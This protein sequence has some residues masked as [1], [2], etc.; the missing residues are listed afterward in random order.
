M[1]E[2]PDKFDGTEF[3]KEVY[4]RENNYEPSIERCG[5]CSDLHSPESLEYCEQCKKRICKCC[6]IEIEG[7]YFCGDSETGESACFD[8]YEDCRI[9]ELC[10]QAAKTGELKDLKA[11]LK[12]RIEV[13]K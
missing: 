2:C 5:L 11:Y 4:E 7:S 8:D 13:K 6:R 9:M 10:Q 3:S 12:T 1:S